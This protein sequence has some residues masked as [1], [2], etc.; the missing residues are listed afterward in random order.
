MSEKLLSIYDISFER[1]AFY[2]IAF[3]ALTI[4]NSM[5]LSLWEIFA[6]PSHEHYLRGLKANGIKK[7][8]FSNALIFYPMI[9]FFAF[10]SYAMIAMH[11]NAARIH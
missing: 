11:I 7:D 10:L 5:L 3:F 1:Y 2:W 9:I 4:S 6:L 8:E